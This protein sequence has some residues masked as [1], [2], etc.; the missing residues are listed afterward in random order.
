MIAE[1]VFFHGAT[2]GHTIGVRFKGLQPLL[3]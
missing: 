2:M 1:T 3:P